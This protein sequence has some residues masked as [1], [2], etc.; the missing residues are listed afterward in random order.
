[1]PV[2]SSTTGSGA[3]ANNDSIETASE[4][5]IKVEAVVPT[6][7]AELSISA[8]AAALGVAAVINAKP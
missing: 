3:D 6:P 7:E 1:M 8:A 4:G 2:T 5:T